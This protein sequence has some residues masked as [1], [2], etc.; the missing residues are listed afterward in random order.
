MNMFKTLTISLALVCASGMAAATD[1]PASAVQPAASATTQGQDSV[2]D[3]LATQHGIRDHLDKRDGE[4]AKYSDDAVRKMQRAQDRIFSMLSGVDSLDQLNQGQR[5]ELSNALDQVKA[6][7]LAKDD[8]RL[9]CH[10]ERKIGSNMMQRRC[11]TVAQRN[12][13]AEEAR[14]EMMNHPEHYQQSGH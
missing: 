12:A 10:I 8:D 9:I 14:K 6:T 7:L 11:E 13:N 4:Y 5:T 2:A 1:Q 3:I